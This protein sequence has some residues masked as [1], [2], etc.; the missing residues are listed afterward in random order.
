MK[1]R[2]EEEGDELLLEAISS[3]K[4]LFPRDY[5]SSVTG[6]HTETGNLDGAT[7]KEFRRSEPW[8]SPRVVGG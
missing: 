6:S 2:E 7:R 5:C 1:E 3:Q 8:G 4:T